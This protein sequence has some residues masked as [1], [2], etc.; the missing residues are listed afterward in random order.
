MDKQLHLKEKIKE[1]YGKIALDGNSKSCCM[2]SSDCCG[3]SSEIL[4]SPFESSKAI[5]YDSDKLKLIP[6]SSVLG[7]GC[8]NPTRF[9]DINEGNTVVDLGSGAGID[10]FLAANLVKE[11][12]KVIGIDMT[13]NMLKRAR[14]NAEKNNYRNVE[15]R[16]GDIEQRIPVEN[17]SVDLVISNCVIN[18]TTNKEKTF[19]EIY[20]ILKPEGKGKMIISDLVTS[21][22]IELNFIN[23]ENWCSCIDGALTKE[24]Y[25]DSIKKAGFTNVEILDEKLYMELDEVKDKEDQEKRQISSISIRAV[26]L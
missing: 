2:P 16:Q 15:F 9:A 5:G 7:V 12:G 20:R 19:R 22:E 6:E 1:Q 11:S 18:L 23:T 25:I 21:R 26:K 10:V 24:N 4:F 3:T 13:E 14:E 8:G 17:D